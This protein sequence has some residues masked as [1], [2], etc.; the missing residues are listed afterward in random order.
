MIASRLL[1][2]DGTGE[3]AL[4]RLAHE[5]LLTRWPLL[6]GLV[7]AHRDFLAVR[8]RIDAD[9]ASWIAHDRHA[10]FLLPSGRRLAEAGD[11][12]AHQRGEL[13]R[14][15]I[16]L[17]EAS[18]DAERQRQE[19]AAEGRR[20]ELEERA[21]AAEARE[22]VA[23][24]L[25]KRT[26]TAAIIVSVLLVAMIATAGLW[27]TQREEAQRRAAEAESSY[28]TA[29]KGASENLTIIQQAAGAGRVTTPVKREMLK[30]TREAFENLPSERET[31]EATETRARLLIS[32]ESA[33]LDQPAEL[34]R[35]SV[36]LAR[37]LVAR[38][39]TNANWQELL[40]ETLWH[41][42]NRLVME[43]D[44]TDASKQLA[45][46]EAIATKVSADQ[47]DD[48]TWRLRLGADRRA[49]ASVM[50]RRGDLAGALE[51]FKESEDRVGEGDVLLAQGDLA[52]A[53]D[54]YRANLKAV[55]DY[56]QR[57]GTNANANIDSALALAHSKIGDLQRLQ[58]DLDGSLKEYR[59]AVQLLARLFQNMLGSFDAAR[60]MYAAARGVGDIALIKGDPASALAQYQAIGT[61]AAER[62]K[63]F[64]DAPEWKAELA[65][66]D[67]RI[68]D[69]R[70]A[71]ADYAAAESQY[72]TA[73]AEA[74]AAS[75]MVG[76][77]AGLQRDVELAH[78][79]L[80]GALRGKG[81]L[82]AAA[83]EYRAQV[84]LAGRLVKLDPQNADWERDL[85]LGAAGLGTTALA[86]HDAATATTAFA[87]CLAAPVAT[88]SD[89]LDELGHDP[90]EACR[91]ARAP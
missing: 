64:P 37:T 12:L 13:G 55:A 24:R 28:A 23:R 84:D 40:Q 10:D 5:A 80:A 21:E 81:D 66:I 57:A 35:K 33:N 15:A 27:L 41:L 62:V 75:S 30:I 91:T 18:L 72:R 49:A 38:D 9:A 83:S 1:P 65:E 59:A 53:G 8:R 43:G 56:A 45:E 36:A 39:P 44:L 78:G 42:G 6:A 16:E 76:D 68:G 88:A 63:S 7:A 51:R 25:F 2:V 82:D 50:M 32:L 31:P 85:A 60:T 52:G 29:L 11:A 73:L 70:M 61:Q 20:R 48:K 17:I 19:A 74:E 54:A 89:P 26:R 71:Q 4:L 77:D 22:Q 90:H 69:V 87:Q 58:G 67:T 47:A 86:R 79:R 3:G 34:G 14:A 46:A